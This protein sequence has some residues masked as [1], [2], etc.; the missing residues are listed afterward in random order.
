MTHAWSVE[1]MEKGYPS[2][3]LFSS[4]KKALDYVSTRTRKAWCYADKNRLMFEGCLH[5][6]ST[7]VISIWRVAIN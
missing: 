3:N 2:I 1:E 6:A 4:A 5:V 7:P